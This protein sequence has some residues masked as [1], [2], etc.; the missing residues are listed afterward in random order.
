MD[1][2]LYLKRRDS[3]TETVVYARISYNGYQVKYYLPEKILPQFWNNDTQRARENK[4]FPEFPEFNIRI[5]NLVSKVKNIFRRYQNDNGDEIPTPDILKQ[6]LDS[7]IK[8]LHKKKEYTFFSYL[9]E[10]IDLSSQGLR[11]NPKTGNPLSKNTPKIYTTVQNHLLEYRKL[12]KKNI[13]FN[14]I[15]L[16]FYNDYKNYLIK[17]ELYANTI[18]K[19]IQVIKLIM[20]E[21]TDAGHNTNMAYKSKKFVVLRED[22]ETI[23]LNESELLK[24]QKLD[25]AHDLKLDKVRDMFLVGCHT[26]LRF[27]DFSILKPNQIKDGFIETTQIKTG[28]AV[29]IPVHDV[30]KT[31]LSKYNGNLPPAIS[32]QKFN[33]YIKDVAKLVDEFKSVVSITSTKGGERVTISS[34]KYQLISTHTA[35]R[36]FATNQFLAGLPS[37]TIMAITG[38]KTEKAFLKYIKVTPS[39]HAKLMQQHWDNTKKVELKANKK[40]KKI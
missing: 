35:R 12:S 11:L 25:L 14:T 1:V 15:D 33:N 40:Q 10:M 5:A 19:H 3:K 27:S 39:E 26:G 31:I 20:N 36:S 24:L 28:G 22:A 38:H 32:N 29:V 2:K 34:M 17:K 4:K 18:G 30:V 23:Y 9:Q 6:L 21:C 13:D 8:G 7:G 16:D 37:I